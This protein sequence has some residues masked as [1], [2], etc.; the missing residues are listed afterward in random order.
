MSDDEILA[1]LL[2]F[3]KALSDANRLKIIGILA[4][5]P[6][7]VEQIADRLG[8]GVSTTSHHLARLAEAGLVSARAEGHYYYY[9]LQTDVL[10]QK[11]EKLLKNDN[12]PRLSS[13][14]MDGEAYDRK[15]LA[16]FMD[17]T[18]RIKAFPAQEKK[19]QVILR[20]VVKSFFPGRR[21][22]E[23]EVNEILS[24][25]HDDTA[26]LRRGLIEYHLMER[27]GGGG[28]YWIA[29]N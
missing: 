21:Y 28:D 25:F 3:F 17:E 12:L 8:I 6:A 13:G 10:Q 5:R 11:A 15:V 20:Q 23:K 9:S 7:S 2:D 22:P 24:R 26:T 27:A 4:S 19:F 29:E 18:G 14:S 16:T 1:E